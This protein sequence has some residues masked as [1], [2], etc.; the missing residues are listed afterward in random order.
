MYLVKVFVAASKN[1]THEHV[2]VVERFF[3]LLFFHYYTEETF[4]AHR[5]IFNSS[6]DFE[7]LYCFISN[8][9]VSSKI[10]KEK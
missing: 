5:L 8:Y 10:S 6:W 1:H 3:M 4:I 9:D 2:Y 7:L